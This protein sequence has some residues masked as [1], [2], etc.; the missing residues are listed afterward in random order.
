MYEGTEIDAN[1]SAALPKGSRVLWVQTHGATHWAIS[2][3]ID[4]ELNGEKKSY[5]VKVFTVPGG[6]E[7]V[8]GEYEATKALH[9]VVPDNIPE[10][11]AH[12]PLAND[13]TRHFFLAEFRYM[14]DELPDTEDIVAVLTKIHRTPSPNGKWGFHVPTFQGP[15]LYPTSWCDTWEELFTRIF[16]FQLNLERE[17][18]GPHEE[19]EKMGEIIVKKVIPRLLRP[20]ETGDRPI[21]PV[22]LHADLW[23]GNIGLDLEKDQP[24]FYDCGS[25]Y[26]HNEYDFGMFR[27]VRYRTNR[28]HIR[29]YHRH[30]EISSPAEDF[31]DRNEL[32]A[33]R[34]D[35]QTSIGWSANKRMR[36]LAIEKMRS[37]TAKF[38]DGLDN[39]K[40][41][42]SSLKA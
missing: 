36:E 29:A 28:A 12:G 17:T 2:T 39:Y 1:L 3:K 38:P 31:D 7:M 15:T 40:P 25:F 20:L 22:L 11:I 4:T 6:D 21:K 41:E 10:A 9:A 5:F 13:P 30:I 8:Q 35:L 34:N 32:Y 27:E 18:Q 14:S 33:L 16:I 42:V 23:H 24:V 26:G 37:L 19:M